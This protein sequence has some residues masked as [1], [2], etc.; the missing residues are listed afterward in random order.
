[1]RVLDTDPAGVIATAPVYDGGHGWFSVQV[2][3]LDWPAVRWG[4]MLGDVLAGYRAA[5]DRAAWAVVERGS[6]PPRALTAAQRRRVAFPLPATDEALRGMVRHCVPGASD[7]DLDVIRWAQRHQRHGP[8]LAP[9]DV[10]SFLAAHQDQDRHRPL[11]LTLR[12]AVDYR[13][14]HLIGRDCELLGV[15]TMT[16]GALR[17]GDVVA[18]VYVRPTGPAPD[19]DTTNLTVTAVP[20][21]DTRPLR[22]MLAQTTDWVTQVLQRFSAQ[23]D[24]LDLD[25]GARFHR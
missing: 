23:P 21:L 13:P 3:G 16:T 9:D 18:R 17:V 11:E 12:A 2:T 10:L 6:T 19:F 20:Y 14:E 5:L 15:Q 24:D 8:T 4:L 1:M 25:I 7:T 22:P